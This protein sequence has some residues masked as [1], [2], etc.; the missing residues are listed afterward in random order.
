MRPSPARPYAGSV[1]TS[2]P[3]AVRASVLDRVQQ[4]DRR[5]RT[6]LLCAA[7]IGRRFDTAVLA[8]AVARS[9]GEI[10]CALQ[11]ACALQLL[12]RNDETGTRFTFRHA[13]TQDV[14]YAELLAMRTQSLHRRIA[15]ALERSGGSLEEIAYHWWAGRSRRRGP[16]ANEQA[17]D[18]AAALHSPQL[19][20]LHYERALDLAVAGSA[21][22]RRITRK[23]HRSQA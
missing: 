20:L 16:A 12:E 23:L 6:A 2:V 10:G 7:V 14:L 15:R 18:E 19:A 9:A 5:A 11:A 17:G 1:P 22:H 21:A 3:D 13:L 8:A 4:L